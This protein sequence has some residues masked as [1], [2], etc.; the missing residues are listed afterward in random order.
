MRVTRPRATHV[1]NSANRIGAAPVPVDAWLDG[2]FERDATV[3][4]ESR[5]MPNYNGVLT[6]LWLKDNPEP[7]DD[8]ALDSLDP[9]EFGLGRKRWPGRSK[10]R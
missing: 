8:D 2:N 3:H 7:I 9:T 6:L 5:A 4:E 10:R 1:R